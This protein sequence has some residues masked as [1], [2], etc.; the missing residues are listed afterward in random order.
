MTDLLAITSFPP[1]NK[2]RPR[3]L[4]TTHP[5][6]SNTSAEIQGC[7]THY[8]TF[9]PL[10]LLLAPTNNN[11]SSNINKANINNKHKPS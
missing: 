7:P 9:P 3:N 2:F 4:L 8:A 5:L 1:Y 10:E 11:N 6:G